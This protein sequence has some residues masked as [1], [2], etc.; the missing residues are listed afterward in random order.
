MSIGTGSGN[1][2]DPYSGRTGWRDYQAHLKKTGAGRRRGKYVGFFMAAALA[3]SALIWI[4]GGS[5]RLGTDV[6]LPHPPDAS[7]QP[8]AAESVPRID[9]RAIQ[10]VLNSGTVLNSEEKRL[11][12]VIEDRPVVIDT[13]LNMTLQRFL[14]GK[15]DPSTSKHI[16]IVAM[17]P[18]SG[19]I[20]SMVGYDKTR[21]SENL[22]TD[23]L[24]PAASVFKIVTAAA[25]IEACGLSPR[26]TLTYNGRKHTLYK[27]QL[28]EQSNRWTIR[29]TLEKSFAQSINPVFGKIGIHYLGQD[30]LAKYADGFGFNR[31]IPF[32]IPLQTS[33]IRIGNEPF[34]WAEVASGFNR[35]TR[36][37][38]V[39]GAMMA[40]VIANGGVLME[41][42]VVDHV[43]D[44]AGRVIYES[45]PT[46][47]R[48]V[49]SSEVTREMAD[50]MTATVRYGTSRGA[51]RKHRK[52]EILS[53]LYIGGKTGSIDNRVHDARIDWFVGF[54]RQRD[55]QRQLAVSVV[56]AHEKYIGT[57][58]AEYARMTIRQYFNTVEVSRSQAP[59]APSG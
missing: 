27:S 42:T 15:L 32:E 24:F 50:L 33:H 58:A 38:I 31:E 12:L 25:V 17:D 28:K 2:P 56:V 20:V 51:F 18:S 53:I 47:I 49:L 37:S 55:G 29:T 21:R 54:A 4:L 22:C 6:P 34:Q 26:S 30:L 9:K 19:R 45:R 40:A 23:Q 43:R 59:T 36:I 57:R 52:D 41:P 5:S 13:S 46:A 16:G 14:L 3:V 35:D 1:Y 39:H 7:L 11:D 44:G 8:S 10:A 48:Q